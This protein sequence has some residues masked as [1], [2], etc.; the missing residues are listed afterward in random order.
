MH[1][2]L[3]AVLKSTAGVAG[4]TAQAADDLAKSLEGVTNFDD[5]AVLSAENLLLT[6]T[7]IGK[8]IFPQTTE[9]VL[10][11]GAEEFKPVYEQNDKKRQVV[12][13]KISFPPVFRPFINSGDVYKDG[14]ATFATTMVRNK[15]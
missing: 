3:N 9:T 14:T 12:Y 2:Q 1:N 15:R 5:E 10:V 11:K 7:K 4:V 6:F 8:D 13:T